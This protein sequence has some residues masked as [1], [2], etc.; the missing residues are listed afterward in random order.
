MSFDA[1][2][3]R[4][5]LGRPVRVVDVCDSTNRVAREAASRW[6]GPPSP[7]PL[8]VAEQQTAGRG[9]QGRTW[10]AAPG[11]NLLWSMVLAPRVP[12]D[13]AARCVMV[14]AA[15]MADALDLRVKWPNDLLAAD[16]RKVAGILA[17]L[18]LR[19]HPDGARIH[20]IVLG[21]GV[22]VNQVEFPDLPDATSLARIRGAP[23]DR[24]AVLERLVRAIEA[25]PLRGSEG[26]DLWR[27]R[28]ATLG[29]RVE[30]GGVRGIAEDIREDGAL[31]V[32]GH[33]VLAGDVSLLG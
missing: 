33:A 2:A 3:L 29:R 22:N 4:R 8:I 1:A 7:G 25:A 15:V 10:D 14:W 6:P 26:L 9:R 32:D 30:V 28:S 5:T 18:E 20:S 21:V 27:S 12:P 16:G 24:A 31:I 13:R 17:E 11:Q 23:L 19:P